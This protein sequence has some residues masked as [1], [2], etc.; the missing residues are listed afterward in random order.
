VQSN[1]QASARTL[2]LL[3][4]DATKIV[5]GPGNSPEHRQLIRAQQDLLAGRRQAA[6][7]Q[8]RAPGAEILDEYRL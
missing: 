3:E 8:P 7:D 5:N 1:A 4:L 2:T 6:A